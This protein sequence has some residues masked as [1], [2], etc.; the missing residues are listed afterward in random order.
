[1]GFR[2]DY[3]PCI[4]PVIDCGCNQDG[5]F[6]LLERSQRPWPKFPSV[7][8][9]APVLKVSERVASIAKEPPWR[10]SGKMYKLAAE[11]SVPVWC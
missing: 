7:Q 1:M 8:G 10:E 5:N 3:A 4:P 11:D 9:S 2:L 6:V